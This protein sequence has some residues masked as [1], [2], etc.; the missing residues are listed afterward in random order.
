MNKPIL[1]TK[2]FLLYYITNDI[3]TDLISDQRKD[4]FKDERCL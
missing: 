4:N 1:K 2:K 3:Y